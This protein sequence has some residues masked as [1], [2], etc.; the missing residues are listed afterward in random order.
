MASRR[1][2]SKAVIEDDN[3]AE[4]S[5]DA[6]LLYFYLG[7]FAD[8]DGFLSSSK[9][10]MKV[11]DVNLD[12]LEELVKANYLIRFDSNVILIRHWK[13]NNQIRSDRHCDTVHKKEMKLVYFDNES[14]TYELL[15]NNDTHTTTI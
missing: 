8:D 11:A 5:K 1:M 2:F 15:A 10:V 14:K 13:Q 12:S 3:F 9:K 6:R 4:L 7:L